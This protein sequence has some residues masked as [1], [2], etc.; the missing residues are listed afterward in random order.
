MVADCSR[1][2]QDGLLGIT[3]LFVSILILYFRKRS[4]VEGGCLSWLVLERVLLKEVLK[5]GLL[6]RLVLFCCFGD[7]V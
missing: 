5:V 7:L 2:H 4:Q 3:I 1:L 6:G